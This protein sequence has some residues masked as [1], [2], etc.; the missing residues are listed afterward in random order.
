MAISLNTVVLENDSWC[1]VGVSLVSSV[2]ILASGLHY[3]SH[4]FIRYVLAPWF[5]FLH[6][7]HNFV[8][9]YYAY[10]VLV[11]EMQHVDKCDT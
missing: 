4:D 2:F 9:V 7:F 3:V 10:V 5:V 1:S 11:I 8:L 6:N